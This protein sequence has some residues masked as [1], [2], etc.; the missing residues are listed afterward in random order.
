MSDRFIG[1]DDADFEFC[2]VCTQEHPALYWQGGIDITVCNAYTAG[3]HIPIYI[4]LK[5]GHVA[6]MRLG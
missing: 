2:Q 4:T 1:L 6:L 5:L 3:E